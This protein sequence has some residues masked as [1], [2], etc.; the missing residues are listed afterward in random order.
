MR[1][2]L[3]SLMLAAT[4]AL[5]QE[6]DLTAPAYQ[7]VKKGWL[8]EKATLDSS[9]T[10]SYR[11]LLEARIAEAEADYQEKTAVR[12]VKGLSIAR[13]AKTISE[14][15]LDSVKSN[16][17]FAVPGT[18][19][20]ELEDWIKKLLADKQAIDQPSDASLANL[21]TKYK[22]LF[23]QV[24]AQQ[25]GQPAP[26]DP[27]L[28]TLFEKLLATEPK[29]EEP[30]PEKTKPPPGTPE[31]PDTNSPWFASSGES[32]NWFT[33]GRWTADMMGQDI[34]SIPILNVIT[35]YTGIKEHGLTRQASSYTYEVLKP[36]KSDPGISYVFRLKRL[37]KQESVSLLAWPSA[38]S[39]G[40]LEFRTQP[41]PVIPNPH[42]FELEAAVAA[43]KAV[44][45]GPAPV[46]VRIESEPA[47]AQIRLNDKLIA[48]AEGEAVLTPARLR[49]PPGPH[50][51]RLSLQ[52]HVTKTYVKWAPAST[53]VIDWKFQHET[54]LPPTVS[55]RLD[56][57]KSW[58][59]TEARVKIGDRIWI[60][61][62]GKW[63]I[64]SK[65][66]LC[67]PEG[68]PE[69]GKFPHYY[70][71]TAL[72]ENMDAPYA[73][74]LVRFGYTAEP[75]AITGPVKL[76]A[77]AQGILF[78]DV[79]EKPELRKDNR[80]QMAVNIIVIPFAP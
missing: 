45:S 21:R 54:N 74:L 13:K 76:Q 32:T 12:N 4:A 33:A 65:S 19:R 22:G 53:P 14:E 23:A 26:V 2:S 11:E 55:I 20:R 10:R 62:S 72:R 61:P 27:A 5:A 68:Y 80:G 60:V 9:R 37:P 3:L 71:S 30:P 50:T 69:G 47:G 41:T 40:R 58:T 16:G 29:K 34:I 38:A 73:C 35:S 1:L 6:P 46:E 48:N 42:G 49:L 66:E 75:I 24:L 52:D 67:G 17:T 77:P 43:V 63:T 56:P 70:S 78:F 7:N 36:V 64:G 39:K 8:Q 15:A 51:L 28:D 25:T 31:V 18:V 57:T 79:N 44:P 59:P